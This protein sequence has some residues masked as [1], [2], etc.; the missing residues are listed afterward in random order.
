MQR[1]LEAIIN[2][3]TGDGDERKKSP[4]LIPVSPELQPA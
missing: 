4:R 2:R 1:H 3:L